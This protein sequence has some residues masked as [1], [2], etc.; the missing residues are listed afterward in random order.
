MPKFFHKSFKNSNISLFNIS[1][2]D[3]VHDNDDKHPSSKLP[4]T[5]SEAVKVLKGEYVIKA[6]EEQNMDQ[7]EWRFLIKINYRCLTLGKNRIQSRY[8][9]FKK[10]KLSPP[11]CWGYRFFWSS[12]LR[13]WF[14][15]TLTVI[16]LEFSSIL[17][18]PPLEFQR[19]LL[20]SLE[21]SINI[22]N[23]GLQ[24]LSEKAQFKSHKVDSKNRVIEFS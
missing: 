8:G 3:G 17:G 22:L 13:G 16:P 21:F 1:Q 19:F 7:G 4:E 11:P 2:T 6:I 15:V 9:L 18:L 20:Y 14:T 12:P 10:K 5:F 24:F 23:R